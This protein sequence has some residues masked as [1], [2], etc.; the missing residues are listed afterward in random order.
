MS[1]AL[2]KGT[3]LAILDQMNVQ[4]RALTGGDVT[5]EE[6]VM[7]MDCWRALTELDAKAREAAEIK[8]MNKR[9]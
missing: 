2:D 3:E 6:A 1:A 7:K 5:K 4:I 8:K 9:K